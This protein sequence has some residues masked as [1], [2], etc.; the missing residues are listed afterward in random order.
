M[1]LSDVRKD[2]QKLPV[3]T[4]HAESQLLINGLRELSHR[5]KNIHQ[6]LEMDSLFVDTYQ[7]VS[8][9]NAAI[10]LHSHTFYELIYCRSCAAVGYLVGTERYKLQQGDLIFIPPGV[11]HCPILPVNMPKPYVRDVLWISRE[12][13]NA[14]V[15]YLLG[16]HDGEI[17][18]STILH[19]AGTKWESI[20][21]LF[22]RGIA[23]AE[24]RNPGW[25]AAVVASTL[26]ILTSL[27]R[28]DADAHSTPKAEKPELLDQ[29]LAYIERHLSE[30]ITLADVARQF[31]ISESTVSQTFRKKMGI[32]FYR[33]VIQRR[34][35]AAKTLIE[36]GL[37]ME[38]VAEQVGFSDYS[39]FYRAFRQEYG[40][41]PKQYRKLQS[42]NSLR[43][44]GVEYPA[45]PFTDPS[46]P[47]SAAGSAP[48]GSW[49]H[50][51]Q[52]E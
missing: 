49:S 35:I 27:R 39:A 4:P 16:G 8:Y 10:H 44:V 51:G 42:V 45:N 19:T 7:D 9:A 3:L 36:A 24:A 13:M 41:S 2:A 33:C 21:E 46:A 52:S 50:S 11:S 48:G 32:S 23:E 34:L 43:P 20:G 29:V 17:P 28:A 31:F 38:A 22:Q 37:P 25:E 5:S 6:D 40:I 26:G 12:F 1:K 18:A 15:R 47:P 30:R 14:T